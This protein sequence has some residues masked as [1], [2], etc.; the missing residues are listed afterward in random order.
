M[1]TA[2]IEANTDEALKDLR[3]K[4]K[5]AKDLSVPMKAGAAAFDLVIQD[6]FRRGQD[7]EG[8]NWTPLSETTKEARRKGKGNKADTILVDSSNLQKSAHAVFDGKDAIII[9][10]D[11]IY[12]NAQQFG[13]VR[14]GTYKPPKGPIPKKP[15]AGSKADM[16]RKRAGSSYTIVV[17]ARP[18]VPITKGGELMRGGPVGR[19]FEKLGRYILDW[20]DSGKRA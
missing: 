3:E 14:T 13:Y 20:I 10:S 6:T 17:P 4:I 7:P 5:R 16:K 19:A 9:S 12:A 18:F 15:K 2:R 1:V 11:R 8:K